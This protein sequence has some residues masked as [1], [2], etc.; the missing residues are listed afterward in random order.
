MSKEQTKSLLEKSFLDLTESTI[1]DT[2]EMCAA[3]ADMMALQPGVD[4]MD[5]RLA[6]EIFSQT[7]RKHV[8]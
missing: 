1:N 8:K 3:T 6:L 5:G 7:I 2:I 4:E